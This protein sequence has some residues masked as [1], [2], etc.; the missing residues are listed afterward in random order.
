M[1]IGAGL[2]GT[3]MAMRLSQR[4]YIVNI[5]EKRP[6][7]RLS[8]YGSGRSIN[9]AL[10][11]RGLAALSMVGLAE[12]VREEVIPMHGRMIHAS[13][14]SKGH[15]YP[16][17]GRPKDYINSVSRSGLNL[18]L[19]EEADKF[20]NIEFHFNHS[21]TS[22]DLDLTSATFQEG[23]STTKTA[24]ADVILATDGAGSVARRMF[25][26]R[27]NQIR[28]DNSVKY[29][30]T[31]YKELSLPDVAGDW[32]IDKNALHIWPRDGFMMI[33]LP[34]L[35]KSFTLTLFIPF[36]GKGSISELD[37]DD[38]IM[39]FFKSNFP[40]LEPYYDHML[41]NFH[42]NPTSSLGTLR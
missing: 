39:H 23:E 2:C 13:D 19:I 29:L 35:D 34:N 24:S 3:L 28:F 15:L 33:A 37:T 9:L 11:D 27:G 21:C 22:V 38:K 10:S 26:K 4:G 12:S 7:P 18:K 8:D 36:E 31:G 30:D 32:A 5:Y 25:E 41:A 17:S 40:K 42:D 1:I 14:G 16:Y 20:P 6:D